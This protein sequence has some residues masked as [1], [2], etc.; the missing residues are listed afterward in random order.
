MKTKEQLNM[1]SE[2]YQEKRGDNKKNLLPLV[3]NVNLLYS[4]FKEAPSFFFLLHFQDRREEAYT[5]GNV[6]L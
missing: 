1:I 5:S 3:S 6:S 4:Q 2:I